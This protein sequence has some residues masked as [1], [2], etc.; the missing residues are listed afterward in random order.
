MKKKII[1]PA[2]GEF[3]YSTYNRSSD[4]LYN[5]ELV[6]DIIFCVEILLNFL[7]K[8][9]VYKSI[10]SIGWKYLTSYFIW[11]IV[12]TVV[13]LVN[14]EH[15]DV[16]WVKLFRL[17]HLKRMIIPLNLLLIYPLSSFSKKR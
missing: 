15:I 8:E 14:N 13:C 1:D 10:K 5:I 7:K 3:E 2:T 16:Y 17:V 9:G 4:N 6:I 12:P 11:D